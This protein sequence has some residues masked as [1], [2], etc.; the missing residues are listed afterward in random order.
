MD[1]VSEIKARL[2]I[3]QLVGQYVQ[4]K[5]KG[6]SFVSL[7]PFHN[8][9]HPSFLISPDKGIAYCFACNSGGDIFSFY[10]KIEN[11][12]FPQAIRELAE[13][14]G[15]PLPKRS[16]APIVDKDEKERLRECIDAA[17]KFFRRNLQSSDLATKY[18]EKR[19]VPT[20]LIETFGIGFAPDSFSDTY[21]FLLKEGFSRK[22]II[23]AGLGVQKEL[24]EERIYDRFR[25]RLMFPI[26]DVQGR[27][28]AFGGRTLS[29]D[30]AKYINSS[31]GPLYK[32]SSILFG[33]HLA[34]EAIRETK[35]V[36]MVEGY[37]DVVACHKIGIKNV[38]A[39]SGTALTEEH[40]RILK[41]G[42]DAVVLCLDAD[43]AGQEAAER[44]FLLLSKEGIMVLAA[45]ITAKDPDEAV[46]ADAEDL[47][48]RITDDARPYL[49]LALFRM[50][51]KNF[52]RPE[53]KRQELQRA[54]TL[55]AALPTAV[56]REHYVASFAAIFGTT[57][58][59]LKEDLG[60]MLTGQTPPRI[61][62]K[63]PMTATVTAAPSLFSPAQIALALFT[64]YPK[65]RKFLPELI[66]PDDSF[67]AALHTALTAALESEPALSPEHAER[68]AVLL[69]FCE[70]HGFHEWSESLA[71]NEIRNNCQ[72]ANRA[73][74]LI[75]QRDVMAKLAIARREGKVTDE[76]HLST[77]YQQILKLSK[78]AG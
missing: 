46:Q 55:L 29:E 42:A 53:E 34:R 78:M 24:S 4:M 65:L 18:I 47:K 15:V 36:I 3:E 48:K 62:L 11:V 58:T 39:V 5:P 35:R 20:E 50:R 45:E 28:V 1:P 76:A 74:I 54:L 64:L 2:S 14:T 9:K 40:A 66:P 31:E 6:R 19:G 60:R 32:K 21:Q 10:Q 77:Q 17:Q 37:F 13:R 23:A 44:A 73:T 56:E 75:K 57:E 7:C 72:Q 71:A 69:L 52:S 68:L 49:E 8:D 33:L 25:N 16:D 67:G 41:R 38:V 63:H 27:I 61:V 12:D 26:S 30:D 43:R 59:A 51:G 22:E 70:Q